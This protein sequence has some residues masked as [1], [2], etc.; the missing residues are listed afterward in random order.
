MPRLKIITLY[1]E[2]GEKQ[3]PSPPRAPGPPSLAEVNTGRAGGG[4]PLAEGHRIAPTSVGAMLVPCG[5]PMGKPM[6]SPQN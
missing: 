6:G 3:L 2:L 5:K 1:G 4:T